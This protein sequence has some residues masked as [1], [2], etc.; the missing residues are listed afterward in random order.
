M[1]GPTETYLTTGESAHRLQVD[2]RT[3][4]RWCA[5]GLIEGAWKEPGVRGRWRVPES[6]VRFIMTSSVVRHLR[7]LAVDADQP[8]GE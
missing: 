1:A 3:V 2:R 6:R 7:D 5:A 8:G 4:T